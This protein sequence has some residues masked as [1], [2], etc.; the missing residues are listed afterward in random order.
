MIGFIILMAITFLIMPAFFI[1][2][3]VWIG[4]KVGGL[5]YDIFFRRKDRHEYMLEKFRRSK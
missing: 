3:C 4:G 5:V 1:W 2:A